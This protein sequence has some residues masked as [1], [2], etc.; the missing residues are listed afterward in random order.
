MQVTKDV[1]GVTT[2]F[3]GEHEKGHVELYNH[4]G[5][6]RITTGCN[7][8]MLSKAECKQLIQELHNHLKGLEDG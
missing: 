7:N 3:D 1:Y 8:A 5:H 2:L 6:V 4:E